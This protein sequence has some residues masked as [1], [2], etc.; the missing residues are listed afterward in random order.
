VVNDISQYESCYFT[1]A[2]IVDDAK[3]IFVSI[4]IIIDSLG[5]PLSLVLKLKIQMYTTRTECTILICIPA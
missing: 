5:S 1:C 3:L 2:H 4:E